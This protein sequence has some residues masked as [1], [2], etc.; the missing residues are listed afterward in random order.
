M[1]KKSMSAE[2]FIERY[3][4]RD[5]SQ[6]ILNAGSSTTRFGA[7]CLN[8]DIVAKD[9]VD[10]V[11]DLHDLPDELGPFDAVVCNAV[12]QYC[13]DP[14]HVARRLHAVL[15]TDGLIFVDAPWV[16][17]Y[18]PDTPD[19]FRFSED[20]LRA[21]FSDFEIIE[22]GPSINSG[23]ALRMLGEHI[24]QN[25]TSSKYVNAAL[26]TMVSGLLY[27][28]AG[29]RTAREPWTAGAVYLIARKTADD[30][31]AP[32]HATPQSHQSDRAV[33]PSP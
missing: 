33:Y 17:P 15:K 26:S 1:S 22:S 20:A 16:Q 14:W 23:C 32:A 3:D 24:A 19:L 5:N 21:I 10:L 7:N 30:R 9:N 13:R 25:A 29:F 8:V 11:C 28:I 4:L 27:P 2:Q 18:C 6:T 31:I 12:L